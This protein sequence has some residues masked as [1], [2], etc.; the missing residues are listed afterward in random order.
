[1]YNEAATIGRVIERVLRRGFEAEVIVV[2]DASTDGTREFFK[3]NNHPRVKV[4]YHEKNMGKE[5]RC[6]RDGR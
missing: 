4:L 6:F 5:L 2:D 3:R 1:M